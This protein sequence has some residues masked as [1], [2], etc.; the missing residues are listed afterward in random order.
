VCGCCQVGRDCFVGAGAVVVDHVRV[1]DGT[2][3]KATEC[4]ATRETT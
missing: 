1:P 4:F 2:R 3:I